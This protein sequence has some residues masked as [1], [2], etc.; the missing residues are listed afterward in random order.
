[1]TSL[2]EKISNHEAITSPAFASIYTGVNQL[3]GRPYHAIMSTA[4]HYK[5]D[6]V[7]LDL[8]PYPGILNRCLLMSSHYIVIPVCL[9]F[10]CLEMMHMMSSNLVSWKKKTSEIIDSTRKETCLFP[11]PGHSPK[12]LGYILNIFTLPNTATVPS[13]DSSSNNWAKIAKMGF[14]F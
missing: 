14:Y 11:W 1:M 7:F 9:D 10:F 5:I 3:S 8:N 4:K 12:F 13:I 2:D 6:Y